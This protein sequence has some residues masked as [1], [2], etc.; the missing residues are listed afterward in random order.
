MPYCYLPIILYCRIPRRNRLLFKRLLLNSSFNSIPNYLN[1][2]IYIRD[3]S[4]RYLIG[5]KYSKYPFYIPYY[6]RINRI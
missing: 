1:Y 6:S 3:Y 4:K 5:L 2:L